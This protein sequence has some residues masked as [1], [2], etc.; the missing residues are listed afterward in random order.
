MRTRCLAGLLLITAVTSMVSIGF[1]PALTAPA[2][3]QPPDQ[4]MRCDGPNNP[5]LC[6][7]YLP[8]ISRPAYPLI[9]LPVGFNSGGWD[10]S[11]PDGRLFR[12]DQAHT[13]ANGAGYVDGSAVSGDYEWEPIEGVSQTAHATLYRTARS[14]LSAYRFNLPNGQYVVE[15]HMAEIRRHGPQF[16]VF[17]IAVEG[18][19]V[20][21]GLDLYALA[22]HDYAVVLRYAAEVHDKQLDVTFAATEGE[23][24]VSAIWVSQR[25]PDNQPP[26]APA[27]INV[28]GGFRQAIVRWPRVNEADLAG[29]QVYRSASPDGPFLAVP[30]GPTP[31][32]RWFDTTTAAG[33]RYCYTVTAID[34]FGNESTRSPV[35]CATVVDAGASNLPVLNLSISTQNLRALAENP[36]AEVEVPGTLTVN[37]EQYAVVA[38]YRGQSTQNSN[39]KSWKLVADRSITAFQTDTLLLNG[40]G[41]D[42]AMIREKVAYDLFAAAGLEPLQASFV[43]LTLNGEFIGVFTRIENPD[44]DFLLRTGRDAEDDVFKCYSDMGVRP[45]CVNQVVQGRNTDALYAFA[46]QV[47]RTP[48]D[49]FPAAIADI[50]DVRSYLDYQ[51]IDSL[52]GDEDSAWQYLLHRSR[53]TGRWQVLPWDNNV[54]FS[55][56]ALPLDYGTSSNP[57][58]NYQANVLLTRVLAAPQYRRY[59]T[60]QL[61]Q[62]SSGLFSLSAMGAR[63]EAARQEVWFDAQ[64]DGWKV[65][66][67]DNDAFASSLSHLP[68]FVAQRLHYLSTAVPAYMPPQ[69]RFIGINEVMPNNVQTI[70]DPA[71]GLA[72]PW[73]EL[74][75]AGLRP[76]DIGG[77]YLTDSLA[78]PTRFRIPAGTVL[79]ALGGMLFWADS[80]PG[81]GPNHVNFRLSASG[82]QIYLIGSDGAAQI[83]AVSYAALAGDTALGRFPDYTGQWL[84]LRQPTPGQANRLHGPTISDVAITPSFPQASDVVTVT[85]MISDDGWVAAAELVYTAGAG[86]PVTVPMFDDG[87]HG[88]DQAGDGRYGAQIPAFPRNRVVTYYITATDDYNRPAFDPAAAPVLTH[89]YRVGLAQAT[90]MISEFMADNAT[91]I[92]DPDEP[93]EYPDWFEL[94]NLGEEPVNLNGYYLTDNLQRPTKF[95][96]SADIIVA[97]GGVVIFWADDDS[98]QGPQHTNFKL[99]KEGE[100]L[101]LFH[102]DGATAVSTVQ[103]GLQGED[104]SYGRCSAQED[105]WEHL[106]LATP[107]RSNACGRLY[108]P[109]AGHQ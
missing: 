33:Q 40:E 12:Q 67:E 99:S 21:Q 47:N 28:V 5:N 18:Q 14:G 38:E 59:Y 56:A 88:D 62:H 46:A 72:E 2:T 68:H 36:L 39:K 26:P 102:H 43:H 103:F 7:V 95:R 24:L 84:Q 61:V 16:R 70:I 48:D 69:S 93:G 108:L 30:S 80:Q 55:Q 45:G 91:T 107:G 41:Y 76:V 1:S 34:V 97:P 60:E 96:I 8:L 32:A 109:L 58:W 15:L 77:M 29:Y 85:A 74:F 106:Y 86:Q 49:E 82:G 51:A 10:F 75:N 92:Q 52:S 35:A 3:A 25:N 4:D 13:P 19:P 44:R 89:R 53:S 87:S 90:I 9:D 79:P 22:Q 66:R 105:A 20:L 81:Q 78:A 31:L 63:L 64:R 101:G 104:V 17:D 57:G 100:S 71:D 27:T 23:P 42:P 11:L 83:D 54:T 37:G 98:Q 94:A 65:H 6:F 50:L 73:F